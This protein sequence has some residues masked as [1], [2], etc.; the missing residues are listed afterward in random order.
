M[1]VV[2]NEP[3]WFFNASGVI[4]YTTLKDDLQLAGYAV[5]DLGPHYT[6]LVRR[7]KLNSYVTQSGMAGF[8]ITAGFIVANVIRAAA[9]SIAAELAAAVSTSAFIRI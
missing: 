5:G 1:F 9:T 4:F 6:S 3:T 8:G 7:R 2:L